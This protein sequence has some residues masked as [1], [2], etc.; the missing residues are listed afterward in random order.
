MSNMAAPPQL[1]SAP[2]RIFPSA[3]RT[4]PT[5]AAPWTMSPPSSGSRPNIVR[6][7]KANG[8]TPNASAAS[9][10]SSKR[11]V[12][13]KIGKAL[14]EWT[15][16]NLFDTDILSAKAAQVGYSM[17]GICSC[18]TSERGRLCMDRRS[19]AIG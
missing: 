2:Y 5:P 8:S 14:D 10:C 9:A 15:D 3:A 6:S 1:E 7:R 13:D 12:L 11:E 4:R 17:A 16:L 18:I 19:R